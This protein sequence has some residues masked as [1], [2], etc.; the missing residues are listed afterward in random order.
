MRIYLSEQEHKKYL[1]W[2]LSEVKELN[3]N[4]MK[5]SISKI[6]PYILDNLKIAKEVG[7]EELANNYAASFKKEGLIFEL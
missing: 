7:Y 3:K 4:N 1:D 6:S 5:Q 2:F